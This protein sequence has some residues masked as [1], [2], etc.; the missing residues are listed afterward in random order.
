MIDTYSIAQHTRAAMGMQHGHREVSLENC[1][2]GEMLSS[3]TAMTTGT[4][5]LVRLNTYTSY[6]LR[7]F[8]NTLSSVTQ[9]QHAS[10]TTTPAD[11]STECDNNCRHIVKQMV[12]AF[13]NPGMSDLVSD[14]PH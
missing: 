9:A 8:T 10:H 13:L 1:E 2:G 7:L 5:A 12:K 11:M 4:I 6:M 3:P 14:A